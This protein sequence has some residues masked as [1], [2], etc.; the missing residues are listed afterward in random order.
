M[1]QFWKIYSNIFKESFREFMNDNALK[2]SASLSYYTLF[3]LAPMLLVVLS[4]VGFF[5]GREAVEGQLY[6]QIN[7]LVGSEAA[8]QVQELIRH[9]QLSGKT[10]VAAAVGVVTLLMGAT[11]VFAEIQDSINQIWALKPKPRSGLLKYFINRLLSFSLIV[12]LGFLFIVSLLLNAVLNIFSE[13][14]KILFSDATVYLFWALNVAFIWGIMTVL[15][16]VIFS[17]LPDGKVKLKDT[18]VGAGVT[19][20]FF[21]IGKY[22]IGLYLGQSDIGGAYGAAGSVVIILLW[23]YYSALILF[24]GAEF[25]KVYA[26]RLGGGIQPRPYAV[27]FKKKEIVVKK[28]LINHLSNH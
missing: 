27:R 26:F 20:V 19:S 13:K 10:G 9:A 8:K 21:M 17:I 24:F 25:T 22:L 11:G 1:R 7:W 4:I 15:F 18:L 23:V 5:Y 3:S 12:S 2:L 14:V 6:E 16:A 28:P